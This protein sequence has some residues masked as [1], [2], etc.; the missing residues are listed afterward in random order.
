MSGSEPFFGGTFIP[1]YR[2]DD[3]PRLLKLLGDDHRLPLTFDEWQ[4][5]AEQAFRYYSARTAIHRAYI[6]PQKFAA[7]CLVRGRHIDND[8]LLE[9]AGDTRNWVDEDTR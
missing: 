7:W 5:K 6:D 8:A 1:W 3:Y 9:F 4:V 2:R